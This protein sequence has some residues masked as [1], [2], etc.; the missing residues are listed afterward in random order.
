MEAQERMAV[1]VEAAARPLAPPAGAQARER[2][3]K[4]PQEAVTRAAEAGEAAAGVEEV[5]AA[6]AAA[7]QVTVGSPVEE[8]GG[9]EYT[10]GV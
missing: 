4:A 10:L 3:E 8:A 2:L 7:E 5:T 1:K 6:E 9:A